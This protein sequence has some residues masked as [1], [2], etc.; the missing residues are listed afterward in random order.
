[1][2]SEYHFLQEKKKGEEIT[3]NERK[4]YVADKIQMEYKEWELGEIILITASTGRGKSYFI[5]HTYLKWAILNNFR[6]LYLV[7]RKILQKQLK[8]E[9]KE[10]EICG[11]FGLG[12]IDINEYIHI[13]TYQSIE[14][15]LKNFGALEKLK[16]MDKFQVVVCDECHYFYTDSN[17]NTGTELSYLAVKEIFA[18][19]V[20]IFIS[21]TMEKIKDYIISDQLKPEENTIDNIFRRKGYKEYALRESY[22]NVDLHILEDE[23]ALVEKMRENIYLSGEKWLVFVDSIDMGKDIKKRILCNQEVEESQVVFIDAEYEND[24]EANHSV[25]EIVENKKSK[26]RVVISTAVMDNGITF[27]DQDLVNIA[28]FADTE[29]TF[30]QM[31]GRRRR[32]H[33]DKMSLYICKRN[34]THFVKRLQYTKQIWN[35]Y[36]TCKKEMNV[37][38]QNT[39]SYIEKIG[40]P[41]RQYERRE[42]YNNTGVPIQDLSDFRVKNCLKAN[43]AI[44]DLMLSNSYQGQC[45]KKIC[46]SVEGIIQPN[47][48]SINRVRYLIQYYDRLVKAFEEDENAFIKQQAEWLEISDE[49]LQKAIKQSEESLWEKNRSKMEEVIEKVIQDKKG[50]LTEEENKEWKKALMESLKFFLNERKDKREYVKGEGGIHKND[51]PLTP[52]LFNTCMKIAELPYHMTKLKDGLYCKIERKEG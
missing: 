14:N 12:L 25:S 39:R 40:T 33:N 18:R 30:L 21:A 43:Q 51:R 49:A 5:L 45:I 13:D 29:E 19:K 4:K 48:F 23:N 47:V 38:Y 41:I 32:E 15:S 24:K 1:M 26:K 50:Q 44:L 28:I 22:E 31:L 7:N 35:C 52:E 2:V 10:I 17:F 20:R 8:E 42:Y 34:R 6:I 9:I 11:E 46:C 27:R 37:L 3:M 36:E 16:W